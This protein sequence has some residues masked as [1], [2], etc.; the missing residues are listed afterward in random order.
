V[1]GNYKHIVSYYT[2]YDVLNN[3]LPTP[4]ASPQL[5]CLQISADLIPH[6]QGASTTPMSSPPNHQGN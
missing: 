2:K 3:L 1:N 4:S 6:L 5:A